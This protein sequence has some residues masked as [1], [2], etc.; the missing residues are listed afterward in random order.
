MYVDL[1]G[2]AA[3]IMFNI[4]KMYGKPV[5][6]ADLIATAFSLDIRPRRG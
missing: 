4:Q 3:Y 2:D 1:Y 5:F 6:L